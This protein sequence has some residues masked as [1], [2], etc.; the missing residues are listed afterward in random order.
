M[1]LSEFKDPF[2]G[3][4][5]IYLFTSDHLARTLLFR[6]IEDYVYGVNTLA[7]GTRKFKVRVLCYTL[8]GTH[9]H[10]LLM[11]RYEDCL[12]F[13]AWVLKHLAQH[14][15][16]R[17]GVSGI[18]KLQASDVQAVMDRDM[19]LNEVCYLLRNSYKAR[20]DSPYSYPGHHSSATSIPVCPS[21]TGL[22][23]QV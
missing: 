17:H 18:L 21:C 19:L 5:G 2:T 15:S 12:A 23:C 8:M 3:R 9:I 10:L 1:K 16:N 14:I 13:Y 4:R 20:I 7:I 11:G 6:D 22:P